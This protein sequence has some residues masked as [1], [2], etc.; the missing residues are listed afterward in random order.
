MHFQL[1]LRALPPDYKEYK[2]RSF[3]LYL[4]S[5]LILNPFISTINAFWVS[6]RNLE[7]TKSY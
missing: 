1:F 7:Y 5:N 3:R 6:K 4:E 2:G